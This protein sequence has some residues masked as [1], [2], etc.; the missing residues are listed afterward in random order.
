MEAENPTS[1]KKIRI[2]HYAGT[3]DSDPDWIRFQLSLGSVSGSRRVK[4]T[5]KVEKFLKFRSVTWTSFMEA[6]G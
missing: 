6:L 5:Q 1:A 3:S 4:M 2:R